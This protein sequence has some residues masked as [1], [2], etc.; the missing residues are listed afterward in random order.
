MLT[1]ATGKEE[2]RS[3]MQRL[4]QAGKSKS[5]GIV[6]ADI[7]GGSR[8][9]EIKLCYVTVSKVS[10]LSRSL[11][12]LRYVAREDSQEQDFY[13]DSRENV[14]SWAISENCDRWSTLCVSTRPRLSVNQFLSWLLI[15]LTPSLKPRLQETFYLKTTLPQ[16]SDHSIISHMPSQGPQGFVGDTSNETS[17]RREQY[18]SPISFGVLMLM[19]SPCK[20]QTRR[21]LFTSLRHFIVSR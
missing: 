11:S 20:V 14:H 18:A 19:K 8:E 15:L 21:T 12:H 3:I 17:H 13:L 9:K 1:G 10:H 6:A 5:K 4:A 16:C 7:A 2:N